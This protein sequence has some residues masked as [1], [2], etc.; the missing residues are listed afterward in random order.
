MAFLDSCQP[1]WKEH[2]FSQMHVGKSSEEVACTLEQM[3]LSCRVSSENSEK[4]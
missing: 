1:T 4:P 3:T 2:C